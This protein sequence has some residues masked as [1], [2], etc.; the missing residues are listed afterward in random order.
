MILYD[1]NLCLHKSLA[2]D[3]LTFLFGYML[4]FG[5]F[6]TNITVKKND[7]VAKL[8]RKSIM[9]YILIIA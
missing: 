4:I 9:F 5:L 8:A 7:K 3:H 1:V 2:W 6:F